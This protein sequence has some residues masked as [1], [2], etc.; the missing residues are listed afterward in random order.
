VT[1]SVVELLTVLLPAVVV[2][3]LD[4]GG[5]QAH[6]GAMAESPYSMQLEEFEARFRVPVA[7]QSEVQPVPT[8]TTDLDWCAGNVPLGDGGDAGG[9]D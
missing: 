1:I 5:A 7:E 6:A 8:L 2:E 4:S 9:C 3:R